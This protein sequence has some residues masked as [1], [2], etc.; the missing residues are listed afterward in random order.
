MTIMVILITST[1]VT[2]TF[3]KKNVN[4]LCRFVFTLATIIAVQSTVGKSLAVADPD[5]EL[6]GG[7]GG[8]LIYLSC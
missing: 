3:S 2:P 4:N 6:S 7:G 5:L 8:G 1:F